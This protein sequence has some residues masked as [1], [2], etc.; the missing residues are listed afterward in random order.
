MEGTEEITVHVIN[1][2]KNSP[3]LRAEQGLCVPVQHLLLV[4]IRRDRHERELRSH[5]VWPQ[6][7]T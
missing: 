3:F 5:S 6:F 2:F 4:K 1:V 7:A